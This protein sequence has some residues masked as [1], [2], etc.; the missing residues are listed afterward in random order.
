MPVSTGIAERGRLVEIA[1]PPDGD[2]LSRGHRRDGA[3]SA[4]VQFPEHGD[5]LEADNIEALPHES[6]TLVLELI[7]EG[8]TPEA[9][10]LLTVGEAMQAAEG[11]IPDVLALLSHVESA[12]QQLAEPDGQEGSGDL[13]DDQLPTR[14][15][16]LDTTRPAPDLLKDLL[17][18]V[19]GCY[20][21]YTELS[22]TPAGP[23]RPRPGPRLQ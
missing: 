13:L 20:L 9:A 7:E 14:L 17:I 3:R 11:E 4:G 8:L 22:P 21:L 12:H 10:V 1:A 23:R 2:E 15:T 5:R 16:P 18:C 19:R 6:P